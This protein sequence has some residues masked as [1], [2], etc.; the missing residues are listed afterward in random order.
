[1]FFVLSKILDVFLSP[2]GWVLVLFAL[3][4]PWRRPR[5]RATWK[6]RRIFGALA[7]FLLWFFSTEV[8]ANALFHRLEH[9]ATPSYH[10]EKTYDA[11]VLLGGAGD[12]R[13][14]AE[15]GQ[16]AFND[17]VERLIATHRLLADNKARY[18]ILS[19]AASSPALAEHSEARILARQ[20]ALW[21]ISPSRLIL[22]EKARNTHENALYS[23]EI[24]VEHG[25]AN[26]V[27][28]T[29]AFHMPRAKECFT[30]VDFPV[31]T[32]ITD[33]RAHADGLYRV[34]DFLPRTAA[35]NTSAEYFRE[36]FGLM[37]YRLQGY[38]KPGDLTPP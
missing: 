9:E 11:V 21:G 32:F 38:A 20:L 10:P 22:E 26:V 12:E 23:R 16:M 14:E 31:D 37:I 1:M 33:Y 2:I 7:I 15:L 4:I 19:G 3:A 18:A 24:A 6:R 34:G 5:R 27:I 13:V 29:S 28:V 25:F 30:A 17:N 36:R 8:V 35:L